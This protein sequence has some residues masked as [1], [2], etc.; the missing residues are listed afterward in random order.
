MSFKSD[1]GG[2]GQSPWGQGRPS[3]RRWGI[4]NGTLCCTRPV[5]QW[6]HFTQ[7]T[8]VDIAR[9]CVPRPLGEGTLVVVVTVDE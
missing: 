4:V 1:T 8:T 9:Y 5:S 3:S 6:S 7:Q 2:K